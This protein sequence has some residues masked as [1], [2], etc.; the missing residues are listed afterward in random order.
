MAKSRRVTIPS[1]L[2]NEPLE[3]DTVSTYTEEEPI[4]RVKVQS[5]F[6]ARIKCVGQVTGEQYIW[7]QSGDVVEADE[8]DVPNLLARTIG[9]SACCGAVKGG[10]HVFTLI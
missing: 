8:R 1:E 3:I 6:P 10:N 2:E 9:K 4:R 7:A 5:R